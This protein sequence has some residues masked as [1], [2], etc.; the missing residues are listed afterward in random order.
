MAT[1]LADVSSEYD[2]MPHGAMRLSLP[3][4]T[5]FCRLSRESVRTWLHV[6]RLPVLDW[7]LVVTELFTNAVHAA[8]HGT[9]IDLY[10][11]VDEPDSYMPDSASPGRDGRSGASVRCEVTNEG[12]W[13]M[14][15]NTCV[16]LD[17]LVARFA[18]DHLPNGRGLK[19]VS[20]LTSRGE[21]ETADHSTVVRVWREI[22]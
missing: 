19:L 18:P 6:N 8:R 14:G 5:G 11:S 16:P 22:D 13:V 17:Y 1:S 10:F 12:H 21:V 2:F 7:D 20:A 9:L 3:S 15:G 4:S